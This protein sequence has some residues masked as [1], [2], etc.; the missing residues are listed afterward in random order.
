[1]DR[2]K[3]VDIITET[4]I[5]AV[6]RAGSAEEGEKLVEAALEGG[7]QAIEITMTVPGAVGIIEQLAAKYLKNDAV[8]IGAGTVLDPETARLCILAGAQFIVS[9]ALNVEMIKLCN[10]Y[11]VA[12]VPG[13]MTVTEAVTALEYGCS[14]L[15]LFPCNAYSPAIIKS[16]KGPLP[17]ASFIPTGGVNLKNAE[18]WIRA[19][20]VALGTGSDLTNCGGD[21]SIVTKNAEMFMQAV[22]N[23][24]NK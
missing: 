17:Q 7:I 19:G 9:P 12:V 13:I 6:V 21:Y 23:A 2:S 16:F 8:V 22:A 5:V 24:R 11:A 18:E 3:V 10:R 15:K 20:A 1:M 4:G 14:V